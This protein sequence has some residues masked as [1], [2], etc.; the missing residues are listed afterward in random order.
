MREDVSALKVA[1]NPNALQEYAENTTSIAQF[2]RKNIIQ[3]V[4]DTEDE[5]R[6]SASITFQISYL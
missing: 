2:L 6:W 1:D 5:E 3:G 4:R